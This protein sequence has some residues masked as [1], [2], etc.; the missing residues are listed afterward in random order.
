MVS[1][2]SGNLIALKNKMFYFAATFFKNLMSGFSLS[3]KNKKKFTPRAFFFQK[4]IKKFLFLQYFKKYDV[5]NSAGL[6]KNNYFYPNSF[7][8][9]I[10]ERLFKKYLI[11]FKNKM[12][13]FAHVLMKFEFSLR[14]HFLP[15]LFFTWNVQHW[16]QKMLF[17]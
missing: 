2:A 17:F 11:S 16:Q 8:I 6:L 4:Q 12:F 7:F 13:N 5:E 10:I 9:R 3:G 1:I 15:W 14:K